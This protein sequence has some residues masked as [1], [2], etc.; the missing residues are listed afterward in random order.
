MKEIVKEKGTENLFEIASGAVS[1]EEEGNPVYPPVKKLLSQHGIDCSAKTAY[2]IQ[3]KDYGKYDML[4]C[5][6]ES[7]L[8][9]MKRICGEDTDGKMHLLMSFAGS[10]N[11]V[12]D[13]WYTRDFDATWRDVNKGCRALYDHIMENVL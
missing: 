4:V 6:D 10:K 1:Y 2:R 9:N 7:N 12:A 3:S 13:P 5:M 8:R 11:S